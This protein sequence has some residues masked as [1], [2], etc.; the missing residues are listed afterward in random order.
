MDGSVRPVRGLLAYERLAQDQGLGLL[1]APIGRSTPGNFGQQQICL[2]NL[3]DLRFGKFS[4]PSVCDQHKSRPLI[5]YAEIAGNDLPKR[6]LQIAAAGG[7][8]L[9]MIGPPGSGKS[10]LAARLST[11][12]PDLSDGERQESA[13]IHSV[14]GMPYDDILAGRR[15]FRSPHHAASRAGLLGGGSPPMPGEVSLAHNGVLFLDEMPEFG[16]STLQLLRQ[17]IEQGRVSLA[18]VGGTTIFPARFMLVAAA[19]PCPCGYLG[20]PQH[21][22]HCAQAQISR[23]QG[24]IGGPLMDRFDLV[25]DVWRSDPAQVLDTGKGSSSGQLRSAVLSA[26]DFRDWRCSKRAIGSIS[27]QGPTRINAAQASQQVL[28]EVEKKTVG[29]SMNPSDR[30]DEIIG[31]CQMGAGAELLEACSLGHKQRMLIEEVSRR[32][33]L[34]GRGIMRT[35]AVART[36]ADLCQDETVNEEHILEAVTYR[37]REVE[38]R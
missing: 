18:R 26:R 3:S 16:G 7:H 34:S 21:D 20:D 11:I 38:C 13:M 27:E 9:M 22:C 33:Q 32:Y 1:S 29:Q 15:P 14:A 4:S 17:P 5:D 6:A 8:A 31:T 28:D 23:Y 24:R 25:V 10:M 12:L 37:V 2:D 19:N 36:I 30:A 35:L